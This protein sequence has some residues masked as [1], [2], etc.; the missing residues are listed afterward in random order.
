MY[1]HGAVAALVGDPQSPT[2]VC[3]FAKK[4]N[5]HF[6]PIWNL[7]KKNF[8]EKLDLHNPDAVKDS[9]KKFISTLY[10]VIELQAKEGKEKNKRIPVILGMDGRKE[11][12]SQVKKLL[13][14][15]FVASKEFAEEKSILIDDILS[16]ISIRYG[17]YD[18]GIALLPGLI[19]RLTSD[20]DA[21]VIINKNSTGINLEANK[22]LA[23]IKDK[24]KQGDMA[25]L[26]QAGDLA[27]EI[28]ISKGKEFKS[29]DRNLRFVHF[30]PYNKK[31]KDIPL[32]DFVSWHPDVKTAFRMGHAKGRNTAMQVVVKGI[33]ER[34]S[35]PF[36]DILSCYIQDVFQNICNLDL[37]AMQ[38]VIRDYCQKLR[39]FCS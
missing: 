32:L 28:G 25:A 31:L 38:L 14:I 22:L 13:S 6:E 10:K 9:F 17:L 18:H 30:T 12:F 23:S 11:D 3:S 16:K 21:E 2:L 34:P 24:V 15:L 37:P 27:Y 20:E 8:S 33:N 5:G 39:E 36:V 19:Q 26:Q 35:R 29:K 1:I 7:R 4:K